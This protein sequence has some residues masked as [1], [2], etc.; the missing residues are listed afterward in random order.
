LSLLDVLK[1]CKY[2]SWMW[3]FG[4]VDIFN[5]YQVRGVVIVRDERI[6]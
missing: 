6:E 1:I 3:N 5:M 2:E 4:L